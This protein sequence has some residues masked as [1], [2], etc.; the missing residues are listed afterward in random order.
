[1][2]KHLLFA[3]LL[4]L[5]GSLFAQ[6]TVTGWTFPV[7]TGS[8][9]LNANLGTSQNMG[10]DLRFQW[11][12]S[13]TSDSTV[14][15]ITFASGATSYAASTPGWDN[16]TDSKF[17]SIKFKAADFSGFKVYS[18]QNSDAQG[19]RDFKLQ[20]RLSSGTYADVPN[21]TV[22]LANDWTTGV[23]TALPVPITGQGTS[24]IYIR[25]IV[26]SNTS[27]GGGT[28][29][30]AG[31]SMIDDILVTATGP[32]G[33]NEI[34]YTNRF[35]VCPSPNNG[36]FGF[37]STVPVGSLI[38]NDM[39]GKTLMDIPDAS[40]LKQIT[41]PGAKPGMYLVKVRFAGT[42]D[43]LSTRFVVQ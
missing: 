8:D 12:L 3:C 24:S 40:G 7:N 37:T 31:I 36:T 19:P 41:L 23:L 39:T 28:I 38:I 27:A 1:M 35:R 42:D 22:T 14:N 13:A 20:W 2:K 10:Y 43:E 34:L 6:D 15:T 32:T 33:Q 4:I 17:W 30:P 18:K 9:S 29:T 25:W 5:A 21:G 16:G 26:A 11:V